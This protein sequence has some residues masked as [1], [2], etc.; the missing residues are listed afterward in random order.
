MKMKKGVLIVSAACLSL[1]LVVNSCK[2]DST[3]SK[4]AFTHATVK[5]WFDSRCASCHGSGKANAADW[6]YDPSDYDGSIKAHIESLKKAVVVDQSMPQGTWLSSDS[7]T[8]MA[9]YNAGYPSK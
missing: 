6:L 2:K 8:F 4:V 1:M 7:S 3:T 9:W 5:P